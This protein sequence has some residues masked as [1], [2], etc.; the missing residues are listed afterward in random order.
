MLPL[1]QVLNEISNFSM[2][3][4]IFFLLN[5]FNKKNIFQN[6]KKDLDIFHI[7]TLAKQYLFF[8]VFAKKNGGMLHP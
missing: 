8:G 5:Q 6:F 3:E 4:S 2:S 1:F 7:K